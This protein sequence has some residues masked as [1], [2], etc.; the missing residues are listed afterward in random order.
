[1]T[2][3]SAAVEVAGHR[4]EQGKTFGPCMWHGH[5]VLNWDLASV[6]QSPR[7]N[8][9]VFCGGRQRLDRSEG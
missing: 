1:M 2:E 6:T 7:L 8:G 5:G 9:R 3:I 4:E